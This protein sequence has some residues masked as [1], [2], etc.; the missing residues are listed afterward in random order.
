MMSH[1]DS[2]KTAARHQARA[3]AGE[4]IRA[5]AS[6]LGRGLGM[7]AL[8][9]ALLGSAAPAAAQS[10]ETAA[11]WRAAALHE[12][13]WMWWAAQPRVVMTVLPRALIDGQRLLGVPVAGR[14][15]QG[16]LLL[17]IL[18]L[19]AVPLW[20]WA[21][22]R[23]VRLNPINEP[24]FE[25][26]TPSEK[27]RYIPIPDKYQ[28][29]DFLASVQMGSPLR[30]SANLNRVSLSIRRFGYLLEDKNFRNA[31][32]VNRRRMR[33]TLLRDG[34][35][36][37]L[38]DL[39]LLY[40]DPRSTPSLGTPAITPQ[41]GKAIVKFRRPRG[42]VRK[43]TP[44]LVSEQY[45]NRVFYMT[46]NTVFIGRSED[47]DLV[48]KSLDVAYRHA[49][50]E[51]VG[52]RYKLIDLAMAGST[53]V[54]NRRVEQRFLKEGDLISIDKERF[55]YLIAAKVVRERQ[56]PSD[57]PYAGPSDEGSEGYGEEAPA[58]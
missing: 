25:V 42:P 15:L 21:M 2:W 9:I 12:A 6:R 37:D 53:F 3:T 17:G 19:A 28:Q 36:L 30:L 45:P 48:V 20:L 31:L 51:R 50:V 46:K 14:S 38:G 13:A 54:N 58:V 29:L 26:I 18:P 27:R 39:T 57:S 11:G 32:L 40:R 44:F 33:R 22:R 34:D 4:R 43:G 35:V 56:F 47:N 5:W 52:S 7:L 16:W 8:L 24:G 23:T 10:A 1:R 41:T 49:K 55:K